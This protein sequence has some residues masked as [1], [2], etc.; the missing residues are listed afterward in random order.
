MNFFP[1]PDATDEGRIVEKQIVPAPVPKT[2]AHEQAEATAGWLV[3]LWR[4]LKGFSAEDF[5]RLKEA[6]VRRVEAESDVKAAEAM[7]RMSQAEKSFAEKERIA[8]EAALKK[9]E[10]VRTM[11]EAD[12]IAAE[13]AAIRMRTLTTAVEDLSSAV[14]RIRQN[15]GD[16]F[17]NLKQ[18]EKLIVDSAQANPSNKELNEAREEIEG[19]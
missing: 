19:E 1:S 15:G 12:K 18:L 7:Q 11:A 5:N 9:A 8:Q 10:C 16:V 14:S 6:G 17:F 3:Q 2:V 13:A 4:W